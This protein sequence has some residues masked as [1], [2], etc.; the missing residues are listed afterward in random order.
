[1]SNYL[2]HLK[3][4]RR[5]LGEQGPEHAHC[6]PASRRPN[7]SPATALA[8]LQ[9]AAGNRAIS[10]VVA[11]RT[12]ATSPDAALEEEVRR[13]QQYWNPEVERMPRDLRESL[14]DYSKEGAEGGRVTYKEIN[15]E[16]RAGKGGELSS[17]VFKTVSN[18]DKALEW[19]PTDRDMTVV[20][21]SSLDHLNLASK[22]DMIGQTYTD[23]GYLSTSLAVEGSTPVNA[24]AGKEAV[25]TLKLPKGTP[26][27]WMEKA[28]AFG[29]D[30]RELLLGRAT[31]Y[32]VNHVH[33][34]EAK[35]GSEGKNDQGAA[36]Q[37]QIRGEIKE[38]VAPPEVAQKKTPWMKSWKG[39]TK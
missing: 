20:R 31:K 35:Q 34:D 8:A 33:F 5:A 25:F 6:D 23:Q 7:S 3:R 15:E 29:K 18:I 12:T 38:Y 21:G 22:Y 36:G 37:W 30:E 19:K 39:W 9:R 11:Q 10:A 1:M 2:P 13:A 14:R 27:V 28:S 26:A 32:E 17:E 4:T 16:L 24:F